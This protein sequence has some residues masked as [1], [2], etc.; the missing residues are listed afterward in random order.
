MSATSVAV[1]MMWSAT[2]AAQTIKVHV[3][4]CSPL[5][6]PQPPAVSDVIGEAEK[7][8]DKLLSALGLPRDFDFAVG[9]ALVE[10]AVAVLCTNEGEKLKK[11]LFFNPH[12]MQSLE[13]H[14]VDFVWAHEIGHI[15]KGDHLKP[16]ALRQQQECEA[17]HFAGRVM[18]EHGYNE[19]LVESAVSLIARGPAS[20]AYPSRAKRLQC[21][22]EGWQSRQNEPPAKPEE[23]VVLIPPLLAVVHSAFARTPGVTLQGPNY[24]QLT[25]VTR[26]GCEQTC[27]DDKRCVA[28]V[29]GSDQS[30]RLFNILPPLRVAADNP[31]VSIK[32]AKL[33]TTPA[34][35]PKASSATSGT[36]PPALLPARRGAAIPAP[37]GRRPT[38][39]S[40][41]QSGL[42]G[43]CELF[44][45]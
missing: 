40:E 7:F 18:A 6:D 11:I 44:K 12:F 35:V 2:C 17:D 9:S 16:D 43:N 30:C 13:R 32:V 45:H 22:R 15:L 39:S 36:A 37:P 8:A 1:M 20:P 28:L 5:R 4:P 27:L 42:P 19:A 38:K 31:S 14:A 23:G 25:K 24:D 41:C 21:A 26:E 10:T 29:Y 3:P 34:I 33:P